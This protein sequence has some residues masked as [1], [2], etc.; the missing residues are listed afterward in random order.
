MC[1]Y[2]IAMILVVFVI[3]VFVH[4]VTTNLKVANAFDKLC[5]S[6]PPKPKNE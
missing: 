5:E 6:L 1:C 2:F 4:L 3:C